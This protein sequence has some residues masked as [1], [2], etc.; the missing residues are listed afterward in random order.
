VISNGHPATHATARYIDEP[1]LW[2]PMIS[3]RSM[4]WWREPLIELAKAFAVAHADAGDIL[5]VT[6]TATNTG[7]AER[8]QP[9]R[10]GRPGGRNLTFTWA[11]WAASH[12]PDNIDTTTLGANRP[13]F[14]WN[15]PNGI[16]PGATISFTFEV[17]SRYRRAA[18][19]G[20]GQ[21]YPGG[22]D[23]AAR[24]DHRPQQQRPDRP[25]RQ[26]RPA[27]ATAPCPTPAMP[28]T[29]TKPRPAI[30]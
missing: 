2:Y 13:I 5:T 4:S 21:H 29:I 19:R 16:A 22:L 17:R 10:A 26:P 20:A 6:V 28:S 30:P 23:L 9:A 14:S 12:P 1:A 15:P 3:A 11:T 25:G 27:C 24:T 8:L 7:T 18:A